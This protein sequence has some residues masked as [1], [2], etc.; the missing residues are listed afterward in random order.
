M[1]GG[2]RGRWYFLGRLRLSA[3]AWGRQHPGSFRRNKIPAV[4]AICYR[5]PAGGVTTTVHGCAAGVAL[6]FAPDVNTHNQTT[7]NYEYTMHQLQVDAGP[8]VPL[9][10][11]G[12]DSVHDP[13]KLCLGSHLPDVSPCLSDLVCSLH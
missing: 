13:T 11:C 5:V 1:V 3:T 8:T 4:L 12:S 9:P 6:G 7:T 10:D 2:L